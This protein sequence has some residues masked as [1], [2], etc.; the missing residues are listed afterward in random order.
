MRLGFQATT[1]VSE[2]HSRS[3]P[4]GLPQVNGVDLDPVPRS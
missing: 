2:P 1:P 3:L 4:N